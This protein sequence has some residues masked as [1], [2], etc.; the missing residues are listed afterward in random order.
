MFKFKPFEK[1]NFFDDP[2][3]VRQFALGL[4]YYHMDDHPMGGNYPGFRSDVINWIDEGVFN[5]FAA[6]V[7]EALGLKPDHPAHIEAFFQYCR[8]IDQPP[9]WVHRDKLYFNPNVV[10]LIYLHPNAP[11][12]TGTRLFKLKEGAEE[13]DVYSD[14]PYRDDYDVLKTFE[15]EYNKIAMYSPMTYHDSLDCFGTNIYDSRLFIVFFMRV[16]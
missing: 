13:V 3:W 16:D 5:M 1:R 11:S 4:K 12:N 6:K 14:S 9:E 15:N 2:D 10:G 7:Y 8:K